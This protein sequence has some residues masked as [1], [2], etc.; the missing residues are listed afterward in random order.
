M[1]ESTEHRIVCI[2][3]LLRNNY[4]QQLLKLA[5]ERNKHEFDRVLNSLNQ[6]TCR[7]LLKSL[8]PEMNRRTYKDFSMKPYSNILLKKKSSLYS[9]ELISCPLLCE[10]C[11]KGE[12]DLVKNLIANGS[13]DDANSAMIEACECGHLEV[14][15]YLIENGISSFDTENDYELRVP[16]YLKNNHRHIVQYVMETTGRYHD[17]ITY[18]LEACNHDMVRWLIDGDK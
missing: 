7:L 18:A 12:L 16:A 9:Y 3:E 10:V 14:L 11:S 15:K 2:T 13:T 4:E 17:A 8:I 6:G 1:E 5:E